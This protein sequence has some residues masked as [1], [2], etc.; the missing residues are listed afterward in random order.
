MRRSVTR[1]VSVA[2]VLMALSALAWAGTAELD[3]LTR[4]FDSVVFG[5]EIPGVAPAERVR[6]WTGEVRY[7]LAGAGAVAARPIVAHH[8]AVLG[9]LTG[10][11]YREIGAREA[12]ETLVIFVVPRDEMFKAG[13]R[14]E[15]ND[16]ILRNVVKDA[17]CYFLSYA[18]EDRIAY[19][20]VVANA[21]LGPADLGRCLME[22]MAQVLG[23]PNDDPDTQASFAGLAGASNRDAPL[24]PAAALMV[25]TLY[26]SRLRVGMP[27]AEALPVAREIIEGLTRS[28]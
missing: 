21:E 26:D 9:R 28:P 12:G 14:I 23:L 2:F 27:R 19:G 8:A 17:R 16:A 15:K 20:A 10:L 4:L 25:R 5:S 11:N 13:Q 3:R 1:A 24:T 7:K 22:E 18:V 6:K